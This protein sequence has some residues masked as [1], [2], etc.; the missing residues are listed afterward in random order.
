MTMQLSDNQRHA[1]RAFCDTIVAPFERADDEDGFWRR[2][3]SELGA[4][5]AVE[6]MLLAIPDALVR[7]GLAELLDSLWQQG[8]GRAP[9]QLSREQVVRNTALG[10]SL[11]AGGV[12]ALTNMTLFVV[13]G[14]PAPDGGPNPNWSR[15]GYAGP[16]S[17]PPQ[18]AK[19]IDPLDPDDGSTL[20]AD[21]CIVGSG[22]GGAVIA[23]TLAPHMKVIVLEAGGYYNEADFAQLE[24][25]AYQELFWH[26]GPAPTAEGNVTLQAGA[27]L[28]GGTTVNWTNCLRTHDWV[29]DE[30]TR[31]F[32]LEGVDGADY[33]RQLDAVLARIG[34][35][36]ACSDL[37]GPQQRLEEGC[38]RLDLGFKTVVRNADPG[39]YDPA[40]AGYL[41]FGDQTGSKQSTVKTFLRDA[42]EAGADVIVRCRADRVL[43]ENGRAA[44]VEATYTAPAAGLARK[45]TVRAPRVVVAGG[46][47]ESPALLLRSGIG[48]P[49]V[50]QYLR[51]HPCTAMLG[52]YGEPQEAFWGPP[53]AGL[54]EHYADTGEGYGFMLETTQ[55]APAIAASALP[56]RDAAEHK[57]LLSRFS[58]GAT[59]IALTRD[60][61]HGQV[62]LDALGESLPLY[63]VSDELDLRNLRAG[64][65]AQARVHQAAGAR[66]IYSLAGPL[67][68][69][70]AGDDLDA[71]IAEAQATPM[72][73]GGQRLF[74]AHQMGT[75]RMGADPQTSVAGPWGE[76][77]DVS[78]V[79]IGDGSAFPTASGTNPM[80]TIMAL[81][82][83]TAEAML[84]TRASAAGI[85]R[86]AV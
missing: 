15:F 22:A 3:A 5:V 42:V 64:L 74:S 9:S 76:L 48:G 46:A 1:L 51:L 35:N 21:V 37:N 44:G 4:D 79:Y 33:D 10:G 65:A 17:A 81:A 31:D 43:V 69:W 73:A 13:Y 30:W 71:F 8:I 27:T 72:G 60:R 67:P 16:L 23:A 14:A 58:Y 55:Y 6:Q 54:C 18:V 83:R 40:S 50:G 25:K 80:V 11:A 26:G 66:E 52:I 39:R 62:V 61:G 34:A 68:H 20:E 41:G 78:G 86:E 57:R 28:G 70:Q 47:L 7:A 32:G 45:V 84:G 19:E 77:H 2:S 29:R 12:G 63:S 36:D 75:C 49:A 53:Q 85:A 82:M 56:W 59:F 24:L 38:R